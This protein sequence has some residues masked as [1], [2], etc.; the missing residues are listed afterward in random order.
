MIF[1][2]AWLAI[3]SIVFYWLYKGES[4]KVRIISA[5]GNSLFCTF[6]NPHINAFFKYGF[7]IIGIQVIHLLIK[8]I[9][10][11]ENK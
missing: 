11:E 10:T 8:S 5:I 3:V 2:I 6:F 7:L 4:Q 1:I 9:F